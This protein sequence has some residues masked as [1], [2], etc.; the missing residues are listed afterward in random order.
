M[1]QGRNMD[2]D[3]VAKDKYLNCI[4]KINECSYMYCFTFGC[5]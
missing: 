4:E 2:Y 5:Y 3:D 1:E